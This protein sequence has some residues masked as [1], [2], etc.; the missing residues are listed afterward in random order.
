VVEKTDY[1]TRRYYYRC[2]WT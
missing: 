2:V 1:K